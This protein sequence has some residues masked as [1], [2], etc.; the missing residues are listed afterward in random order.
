[1]SRD[2]SPPEAFWGNP[3]RLF[4]TLLW[5]VLFLNVMHA[6]R[7]VYFTYTSHPVGYRLV[8]KFNMDG[9]MA[10]PAWFSTLLIAAAAVACVGVASRVRRAGGK[11]AYS[12]WLLA[13]GLFFVSLDE[14]V[15]LHETLNGEVGQVVERDGIFYFGWVLIYGPLAMG[16][17][18]L[19]LPGLW[20]A[21]RRVFWTLVAAAVVYC[22]GA[23]GVE[24]M[25]GLLLSSSADV[26]M[27]AWSYFF[28]VLLEENGEILGMMLML[29]GLAL[30]LT[31]EPESFPVSENVAPPADAQA[32]ARRAQ[33]AEADADPPMEGAW[34]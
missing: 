19:V 14:N 3:R 29:R 9:E 23:V 27:T 18:A 31:A 34:A 21:P 6:F 24:M 17:A 8:D 32:P 1:M 28:C 26:D 12:W 33:P 22:G 15:S 16:L 20:R 25:S 2:L 11:G 4:N 30:Y 10:V 7:F 13:A 5:V